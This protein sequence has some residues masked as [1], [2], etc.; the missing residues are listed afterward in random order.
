MGFQPSRNSKFLALGASHLNIIYIYIFIDNSLTLISEDWLALIIGIPISDPWIEYHESSII[1]TNITIWL[2]FSAINL[3]IWFRDVPLPAMFDDT[4]AGNI[5]L[6]VTSQ[7]LS[8]LEPLSIFQNSHD[9]PIIVWNYQQK[10]DV[11]GIW[12]NKYHW[13]RP[14]WQTNIPMNP[15]WSHSHF[16]IRPRFH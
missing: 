6:Q 5:P 1:N 3:H 15:S 16:L 10:L 11:N 12:P 2:L 7:W 13:I 14:I 4:A 9:I 8:R